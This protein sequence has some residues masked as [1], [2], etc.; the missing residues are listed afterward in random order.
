MPCAGAR[1]QE[2][3]HTES[4]ESTENDSAGAAARYRIGES[5]PVQR[6]GVREGGLWAVVAAVSIARS[7]GRSG[8]APPARSLLPPCG[9]R[10]PSSRGASREPAERAHRAPSPPAIVPL[11]F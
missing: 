2:G 7:R 11:I 8:S 6:K 3:S 9:S 4:T 1:E 5:T 10:S